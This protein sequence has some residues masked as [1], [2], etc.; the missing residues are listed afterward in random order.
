[1]QAAAVFPAVLLE[2]INART[3]YLGSKLVKR[4]GSF[5]NLKGQAD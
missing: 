5:V 3:R 1:M 2:A 4:W